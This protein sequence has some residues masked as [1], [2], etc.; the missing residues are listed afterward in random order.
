MAYSDPIWSQ[1]VLERAL[2][3]SRIS[4]LAVFFSGTVLLL[5]WYLGLTTDEG[6]LA[7]RP[8]P[9]LGFL[10]LGHSILALP[11]VT[12]QWF[13][14]WARRCGQLTGSLVLLVGVPRICERWLN[15]PFLPDTMATTTALGL[16]LI[17]AASVLHHHTPQ[18]STRTSQIPALAGG[19]VG[20]MALLGYMYQVRVFFQL[21]PGG[22]MEFS[23]SAALMF[24]AAAMVAAR[25]PQSFFAPFA[26]STSSGIFLRSMSPIAWIAPL[27]LGAVLVAGTR[28]GLYGVGFELVSITLG[29]AIVLQL[30]LW[31]SAG[32]AYQLE[33]ET[34]ARQ[35]EALQEALVFLDSLVEN[36]PN[37]I[38]VKDA[39]DLRF[40]RFNR[41]GEK[42]LGLSKHELIGKND[43]DFFPKDEADFFTSKDRA[44]L[45][46]RALFDIAEET[47]HTKAHG[48]RI[49]HT[50]KIPILDA[51]GRTRYLLGISEDITDRKL[52]AKTLME[53]RARMFA[54][55]RMAELGT[56]AGGIAHELNTPLAIITMSAEHIQSLGD[57]SDPSWKEVHTHAATIENTGYR[58][59]T[60]VKALRTIARDSKDDP[61]ELVDVKLLVDDAL[62][63]CRE[64]FRQHGVVIEVDPIPAN[65]A[66]WCRP[67]QISQV[68][69]N[70]LNNAYD[71]VE[72]LPDRRI[73][74]GF[75]NS[76][77]SIE[78]SVTDSGP[79][80]PR[81][82]RDSI[83]QPF[84]TTKEIGKGTGLGLSICDG[85]VRGHG[86][87]LR[88]EPG[89]Q[90]KF[91]LSIPTVEEERKVA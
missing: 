24:A 53:E 55:S 50:R 88:L 71:A 81:E 51:N 91:V 59:A 52:A 74:V 31:R 83:F 46:S 86:G 72:N 2:R 8:L 63:F 14:A 18:L 67:V 22:A 61:M 85:I 29:C 62:S 27:L 39:R 45:E 77:T 73:R 6:L 56:M 41:A 19:L 79:G 75:L 16:V 87:T 58:I 54:A 84:F 80:I 17:G 5:G 66:L 64:R 47:I 44:V 78:L 43:Y 82:H 36:I 37:M 68:L 1:P 33:K 10:L 4:A 89:P 9:A 13:P 48:T 35:T 11:E 15:L 3:F 12:P 32:L 76:A 26:Y 25:L 23:T 60:I 38:F 57:P 90:T 49:L 21:G 28:L 70:L 42:L 20:L 69:L 7:S 30:T 40:V 34:V 65:V